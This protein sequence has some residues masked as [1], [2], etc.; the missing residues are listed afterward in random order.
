M[1]RRDVQDDDDDDEDFI[2]GDDDVDPDAPDAED[3]GD[4]DDETVPCPYCKKPVHEQA[5]ICHHCG[6]YIVEDDVPRG[7]PW[8]VWVGL[9]L[10]LLGVLV[11][12]F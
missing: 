1:M 9:I 7:Y 3:V 5:E 11:W 6:R 10:G 2:D 12:I 8:W 4:P